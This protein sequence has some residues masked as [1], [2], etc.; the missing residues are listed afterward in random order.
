[1]R[2]IFISAI[3]LF[4]L[5]AC[6]AD[7]PQVTVTL[8]PTVTLTATPFFT[9]TPIATSTPT[10]TADQQAW[11]EIIPS[12]EL[13]H[14]SVDQSDNVVDDRFPS[15]SEYGTAYVKTAEGLQLLI[16]VIRKSQ[17]MP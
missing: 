10:L 2:P 4:L 14:F 3:I 15:G 8:P 5:A 9:E 16:F 6:G 11:K 12:N 13:S 1:M 17:N 7:A